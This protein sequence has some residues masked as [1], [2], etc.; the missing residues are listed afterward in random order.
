MF[1]SSNPLWR[2]GPTKKKYL[3]DEL[4]TLAQYNIWRKAI[5]CRDRYTCRHCIVPKKIINAHH[6]ISLKEIFK[7][8]NIKTLDDALSCD[9]VWDINNGITLCI[10]CHKK[11]HSRKSSKY[12]KTK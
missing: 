1:G 4:K 6:I 7:N 11:Q 9:K 8:F 5:F 12:N 10:D 2:G 3:R